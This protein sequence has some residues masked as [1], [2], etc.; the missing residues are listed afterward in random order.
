MDQCFREVSVKEMQKGDSTNQRFR[1][2]GP[3]LNIPREDQD[4]A[5]GV[6]LRT[7]TLGS[8]LST[9]PPGRLRAQ[10]LQRL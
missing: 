2:R 6:G 4:Y 9:V 5:V 3:R 10:R 1:A 8:T 7:P